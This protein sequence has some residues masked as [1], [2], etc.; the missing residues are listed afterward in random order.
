MKRAPALL[1]LPLLLLTACAQSVDPIERLGRKAAERIPLQEPPR[2]GQPFRGASGA[3]A[4]SS[5]TPA[6][7]AEPTPRAK[8]CHKDTPPV[9]P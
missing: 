2:C 4:L 1:L 5:H 9:A 8:R 6:P 7:R 3:S